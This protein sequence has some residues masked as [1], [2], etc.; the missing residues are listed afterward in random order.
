MCQETGFEGEALRY[1]SQELDGDL[2]WVGRD[3]TYNKMITFSLR[4]F[5]GVD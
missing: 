3:S 5:I 2:P 1:A 4:T